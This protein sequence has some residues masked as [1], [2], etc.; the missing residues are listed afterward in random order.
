[1]IKKDIILE[2]KL[3]Q[4]IKDFFP[5]REAELIRGYIK[6]EGYIESRSS[7]NSEYKL[8][9]RALKK[10]RNARDIMAYEQV[11]VIL[12]DNRGKKKSGD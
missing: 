12:K 7:N 11:Q 5:R 2:P 1:M 8:L 3:E 6:S 9:I 10:L 4:L